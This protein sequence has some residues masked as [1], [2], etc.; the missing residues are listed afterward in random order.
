MF[1]AFEYKPISSKQF[2]EW[3]GPAKSAEFISQ[4]CH[5]IVVTFDN[6]MI[7]GWIRCDIQKDLTT[8]VEEVFYHWGQRAEAV[9]SKK[10]NIF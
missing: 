8:G 5:F 1:I 2:V 9:I 10:V 7:K 4:V 6:Y 3:F